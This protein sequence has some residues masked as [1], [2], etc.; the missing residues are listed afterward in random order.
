MKI[1]SAVRTQLDHIELQFDGVRCRS[2]EWKSRPIGKDAYRAKRRKLKAFSKAWRDL[3][4]QSQW[5]IAGGIREQL[6][7]CADSRPPDASRV[8]DRLLWQMEKPT[9]APESF[10]GFGEAVLLLWNTWCED[11]PAWVAID[12]DACSAIAAELAM[13]FGID[14]ADACIRVRAWLNDRDQKKGDLPHRDKGRK[15]NPFA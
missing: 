3:D 13:I 4:E 2:E 9:G 12:N 10:Y 5:D 14:Q 11:R 15:P 1:T 8:I 6:E 7:D